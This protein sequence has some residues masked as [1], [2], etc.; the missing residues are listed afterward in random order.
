MITDAY[1]VQYLLEGTLANPP[2][3]I[4]NDSAR[5]G[6]ATIAGDV[7]VDLTQHQDRSGTRI[8]LRLYQGGD[9]FSLHEPRNQGWVKKRYASEDDER[10]A[11]LLND[12]WGAAAAQGRRPQATED[13]RDRLYRR[14][15]FEQ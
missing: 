8:S 14:L 6:L 3:V 2:R 7:S 10:L 11:G 15:L 1:T 12:L 13:I 5:A 9:T 4:W